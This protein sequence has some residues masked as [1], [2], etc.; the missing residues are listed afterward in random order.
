MQ[1]DEEVCLTVVCDRG[2]LVERQRTIVVSREDDT[3]TESTLDH[4]SQSTGDVQCQLLFFDALRAAHTHIVTTM[5]RIDH[6][7]LPRARGGDDFTGIGNRSRGC[8]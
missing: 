7:R 1:A 8:R 3:K 4:A 6:D 5:T 2:A